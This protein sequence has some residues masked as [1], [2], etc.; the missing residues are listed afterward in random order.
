M[1]R[2]WWP[3]F[4]TLFVLILSILQTAAGTPRS[5]SQAVLVSKKITSLSPCEEGR[6]L[7]ISDAEKAPVGKAVVQCLWIDLQPDRWS[8]KQLIWGAM[9]AS[10]LLLNED[11]PLHP[12]RQEAEPEGRQLVKQSLGERQDNS[13]NW[14]ESDM[15][16]ALQNHGGMSPQFF[17]ALVPVGECTGGAE[18]NATVI[19]KGGDG[20]ACVLHSQSIIRSCIC[21]G[22]LE[23]GGLGSSSGFSEGLQSDIQ[24]TGEASSKTLSAETLLSKTSNS[25]IQPPR[26]EETSQGHSTPRDLKAESAPRPVTIQITTS[27]KVPQLSMVLTA[28]GLLLLSSAEPLSRVS[29]MHIILGGLLGA[30]LAHMGVMLAIAAV[31]GAVV[32][33]PW[34]AAL[35]A[36]RLGICE[37][38]AMLV[39]GEGT[40]NSG[41]M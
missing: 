2:A 17:V 15:E 5:A 38:L 33:L 35:S 30:G 6:P 7:V 14:L 1:A 13:L 23:S 19:C 9:E 11:Q 39:A 21:A 12:Q 24:S 36:Y 10:V 40:R 29:A 16:G 37:A 3:C 25:K 18:V 31:P 27:V 20:S 34:I 32:A 26:I 8:W 41:G 4:P 28:V 22:L